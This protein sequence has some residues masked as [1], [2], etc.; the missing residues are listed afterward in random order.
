MSDVR[1]FEL[2]PPVSADPKLLSC[3]YDGTI[4][5]TSQQHEGI[6]TVNDAY[7]E[8]IDQ[9][10]GAVATDVFLS[11][12]GHNHRTPAEIVLDLCPYMSP[13]EVGDMSKKITLGKLEVLI[14]QIGRRV[15]SGEPWPQFTTGFADMWERLYEQRG[16]QQPVDMAIVSA[17]HTEFIKKSFDVRGLPQPDILIT[18]DVLIELG[19]DVLSAAE[20]AKPMPLPLD[21]ARY[22]WE[23]RNRIDEPNQVWPRRQIMHVGDDEHK[24]LGLAEN[25]SASFLLLKAETAEQTWS[26]VLA[27]S[28]VERAE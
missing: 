1:L 27:W 22:I 12:G 11:S 16:P 7:A 24:D 26:Q 17:G 4:A 3:D 14:D 21:L 2:E 9:H 28:G 18:D 10:L 6:L 20:R 5:L 23:A 15:E 8:S 25:N 19:L 13:E